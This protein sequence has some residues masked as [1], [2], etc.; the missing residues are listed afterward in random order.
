VE[1]LSTITPST[2]YSGSALRLSVESP[3]RRTLVPPP[4]V[5]DDC[6]TS[7]PGTLPARATSICGDADWAICSPPIVESVAPSW[8]R[9]VATREPVVTTSESWRMSRA[10]VKSWVTLPSVCWSVARSGR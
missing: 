5:P 8:V 7:A 9:S 4:G 6:M 3:R 2:M 1:L 10:R